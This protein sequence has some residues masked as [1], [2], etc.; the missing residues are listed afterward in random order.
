MPDNAPEV[1]EVLEVSNDAEMRH[2]YTR[3]H[4]QALVPNHLQI[5]GTKFEVGHLVVMEKMSFGTLK[6][7]LIMGMSCYKN[8]VNFL[9]STFV[10]L[11]SKYGYYVTSESLNKETV[12]FDNLADHY[13]L[14]MIGTPTAFM[15]RLHHFISRRR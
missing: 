1:K 13:P 2:Y 4:G 9:V 11:Q 12:D 8:E 6:V 15:F 10:A 7:G 14:L 3:L 5:Y